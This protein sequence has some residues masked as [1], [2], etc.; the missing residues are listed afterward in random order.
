MGVT[1]SKE[2]EIKPSKNVQDDGT[3]STELPR[4]WQNGLA[5]SSERLVVSTASLEPTKN[6]SLLS[7]LMV[8]FSPTVN[9]TLNNSIKEPLAEEDNKPTKEL[10]GEVL[11]KEV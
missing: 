9:T 10:M 6:S 2:G 1:L 3:D 8:E 5:N 11:I 7:D 4:N